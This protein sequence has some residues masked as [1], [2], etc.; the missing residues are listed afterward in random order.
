[1][2]KIVHKIKNAAECGQMYFTAYHIEICK[3]YSLELCNKKEA[4][5][6]IVL[7]DTIEKRQKTIYGK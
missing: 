4:S 6:K 1:M 7:I 2:G 5:T 3:M